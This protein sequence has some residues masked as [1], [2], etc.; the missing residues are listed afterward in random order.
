MAPLAAASRCAFAGYG[1]SDSARRPGKCNPVTLLIE[2]CQ[3]VSFLDRRGILRFL[4][5]LL[6]AGQERIDPRAGDRGILLPTAAA[7]ADAADHL[8]L[9]HDGHPSEER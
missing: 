5:V 7:D 1:R 4:G 6:E 8:L 3:Q 9:D 2:R